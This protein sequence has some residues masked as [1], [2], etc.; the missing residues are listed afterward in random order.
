MLKNFSKKKL[1]KIFKEELK[2]KGRFNEKS[3]IYAKNA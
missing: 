1:I 2:V 3:K